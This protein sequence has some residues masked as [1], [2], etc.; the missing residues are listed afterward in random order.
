MGLRYALL[1]LPLA[2]GACAQIQANV[3][4]FHEMGPPSGESIAVVPWK[5]EKTGSLEFKTYAE[6][7]AQQLSARGF[8]VVPIQQKPQLIA[9]LDYGIDDGREVLSSYSVP[10][11]GVTGYSASQTTGTVTSYGN[12]ANISSNTTYTPQYGVTGYR[13]GVRSE[14]VYT[15][16]ISLDVVRI[17][18]ES[19]KKIYEGRL[20][21]AGSCGNIASLFP[22]LATMMFKDFPGVSG[23]STRIVEAAP[24][25]KC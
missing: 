19:N 17:G 21:S 18:G 4:A 20:K 25:S 14:T 5:E 12:M 22:T 1:L 11:Y 15:R 2:V 24:D 23:K 6:H 7:V 8:R 3:T 9:F 13:S 16:Y 10:Q